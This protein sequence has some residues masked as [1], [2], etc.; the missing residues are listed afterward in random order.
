ML[1]EWTCCEN[2]EQPVRLNSV[3]SIIVK[4]IGWTS[5]SEKLA[6]EEAAAKKAAEEKTARELGQFPL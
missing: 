3:N 4:M 5:Y 6:A 2:I 1:N